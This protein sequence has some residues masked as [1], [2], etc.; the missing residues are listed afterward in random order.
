MR[1]LL[2]A[3]VLLDL[4][5]LGQERI[6]T[7]EKFETPKYPPLAKMARITSTVKL[8]LE[9]GED[10]TVTS[11]KVL[12]G[13]PMLKDIA[14][15]SIKRWRFRCF[16][17]ARPHAFQHVFEYIF[18]VRPV[19]CFESSDERVSYSFPS[20][21]M[22]SADSPAICD[23]ASVVRRRSWFSRLF[24]RHRVVSIM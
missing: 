13:H 3:F 10:G 1:R 4:L 16:N 21:V 15:E 19:G 8:E 7:V 20:K 18:D 23:P 2:I 11:A 12:S 9:I 24:R 14:S 6:V 22:I 5:A 17:C